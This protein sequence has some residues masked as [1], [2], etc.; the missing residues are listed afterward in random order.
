M[1][2]HRKWRRHPH[3]PKYRVS[4]DGLVLS[5][6]GGLLKGE[7][8]KKGYRRYELTYAPNKTRKHFASHLV[9]EAFGFPRPNGMEAAHLNGV[10]NDDRIENLAWKTHV[11]NEADK[12]KHGTA[13]IGERSHLAKMT[14]DQA[15]KAMSLWRTGEYTLQEIGDLFGVTKQAIWHLKEGRSRKNVSLTMP[16]D[17]TPNDTERKHH[18]HTSPDA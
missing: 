7:L 4:D 11:D 13:I 14:D 5:D 8:N 10:N 9:L 17:L 3:Y 2:R 6:F 15:R 12:L 18:D 1:I 16:T